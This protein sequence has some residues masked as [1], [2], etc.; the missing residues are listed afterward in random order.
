MRFLGLDGR[1]RW[2]GVGAS[3]CCVLFC[4]VFVR[5]AAGQAIAV[6]GGEG[7]F[8]APAGAWTTGESV[9][10]ATTPSEFRGF[11]AD[12]F[13]AG[14]QNAAQVDEMIAEAVAGNYNAIV[15]EVLAFHDNQYGSH[16]AYWKSDIVARSSYVTTSFDPLAYIVQRAHANGLEVHPWLVAFRVSSTWPPP[17]NATVAAHPEWLMVPRASMGS[18]ATVGSYYTFDP[19][20]PGVQDYLMSIVRELCEDY[21]IDGIHWDYIRYTDVD[22]G[23]PADLSYAHSTLRRFQAITG[24]PGTP[25]TDYGPWND[26]RRRTITEVVRRAMFE[27]PIVANPR[28]PLRHTAA[29][30][31]WY[32]ANVNFHLTRPYYESFSDWEYW[33]SMGYLD[34]TIP[35]CYFDENS[36]PSTYRAWVDNSVMWAN[37]YNRHTY[38]GPGIY[39]N[40]FADSVTQIQYARAAGA[41]G[42]CTYSYRSTN[43][44]GQYWSNWYPYV[45]TNV[46]T[47]A[48]SVPTMPWRDPAAATAGAVFGRVTDGATGAPIDDATIEVNGFA[49]V[50]TDGNGCYLVANLSAGASGTIVPFSANYAGYSEV[51]RPAVLVE[52]AGFTE[53]NFALGTW[54]EGDY[55]VDGDVDLDDYDRF[56]ECLTD[57]DGGPIGAGCDVFDFDTDAD[58]DLRDFSVIQASFTD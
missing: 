29:L 22:A 52:R 2:P 43:D 46:F 30:V 20:S 28:Q 14:L 27:I 42:I 34:A 3:F 5:A 49:M 23:Y 11:W 48:A 50:Q 15:P 1:T 31:T 41:H 32:P 45:A 26:F 4:S 51:H 33:Q 54:L 7:E 44:A 24:Y 38:I 12:V 18:V 21:E 56:F 53:A 10:P 39:L 40:T 8:A 36:Y 9:T 16:G 25:P 37:N 55:D 13:H 57:P 47:E 19:G 17:G 35:M 58:V 6:D